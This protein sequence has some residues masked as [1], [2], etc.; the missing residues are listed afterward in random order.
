MKAEKKDIIVLAFVVAVI[1]FV[2]AY[3]WFAGY[4]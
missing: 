1:I 2:P 3:Y 4:R